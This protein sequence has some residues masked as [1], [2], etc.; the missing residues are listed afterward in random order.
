[1]EPLDVVKGFSIH[2]HRHGFKLLATGATTLAE[3]REGYAC[4]VW[5]VCFDRLL[6]TERAE[7]SFRVP[8]RDQSAWSGHPRSCSS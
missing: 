8:H 6:A 4:P 3:N 7:H 5:G 1:M 2:D